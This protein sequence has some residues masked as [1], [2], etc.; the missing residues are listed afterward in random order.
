MLK[1]FSILL[2]AV[3]LL[4]VVGCSKAPEADMQAADVV[5]QAAMTAEA[6]QYVPQSYN[7]ALDTLNAAKAA[8][9]EQDSKFA[10]FRSYGKSK[11]MFI[12][13]KALFEKATTDAQAEKERVRV[14]VMD[15]MA[16]AQTMLDSAVVALE[17]APRG[18]GSKAD[19]ELIKNDLESVKIGF[20]EAKADFDLGKFLAARAKFEAVMG[21]TQGVMNEIEAA[22]AKKAG[23]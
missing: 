18:K 14:Q 22:K 1:Y 3:A 20:A 15:M 17:K 21:K 23:K 12:A 8:K 7:M 16:K 9:E 4:F 11:E 2:V 5:M 6:E 13:A 10:L 19:I